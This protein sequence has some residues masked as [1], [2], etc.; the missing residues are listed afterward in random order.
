MTIERLAVWQFLDF[1]ECGVGLKTVLG[2]RGRGQ[3]LNRSS[4]LVPSELGC[5]SGGPGGGAFKQVV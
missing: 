3:G 4:N 2:R 1:G 5:A